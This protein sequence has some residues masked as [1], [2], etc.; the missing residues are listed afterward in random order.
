MSLNLSQSS[1]VRGADGRLYNVSAQGVTEIA[2]VQA[3]TVRNLVRSGDRG[4]FDAADHEAG[5]YSITPGA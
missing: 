5:R 3:S 2:E 1:M 4:T